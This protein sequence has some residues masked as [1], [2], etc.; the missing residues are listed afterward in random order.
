M[1]LLNTLGF[2]L[3]ES[4]PLKVSYL[5]FFR[6]FD[7]DFIKCYKY[8]YLFFLLIYIVSRDKI[9]SK[10]KSI[11]IQKL[12]GYYKNIRINFIIIELI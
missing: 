9:L 10:K 3:D 8:L 12:L 5:S 7:H 1:V 2:N 6:T 11:F 4:A